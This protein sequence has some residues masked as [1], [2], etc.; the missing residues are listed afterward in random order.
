[1]QVQREFQDRL[2]LA[3]GI[4]SAGVGVGMVL[5]VPLAQV[6]IDAYGGARRS[7][8]GRVR[9]VDRALVVLLPAR[10]PTPGQRRSLPRVRREIRLRRQR[11]S[12]KRC[13][14]RRSG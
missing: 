10:K 3:I 4:V 12:A 1:M 5:V 13:A 2:G 8:A 6:L 7:R 14:A 9:A 11:R